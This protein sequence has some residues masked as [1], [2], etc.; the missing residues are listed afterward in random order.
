MTV[1][2]DAAVAKFEEN[3]LEVHVAVKG[4]RADLVAAGVGPVLA[5]MARAILR[6][7][8]GLQLI[9]HSPPL[10]ADGKEVKL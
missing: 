4:D 8:V 2:S 3:G 5:S 10:G 9:L 7:D 1:T 6:G